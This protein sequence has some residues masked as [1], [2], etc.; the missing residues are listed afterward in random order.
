MSK[1]TK[2][3]PDAVHPDDM[4][5]VLVPMLIDLCRNALPGYHLTTVSTV[6]QITSYMAGTLAKDCED[7]RDMGLR[8]RADVEALDEAFLGALPLSATS[9]RCTLRAWRPV[10]I[11]QSGNAIELAIESP[12][13]DFR[14]NVPGVWGLAMAVE[15]LLLPPHSPGVTKTFQ[16]QGTTSGK[17]LSSGGGGHWTKSG[18]ENDPTIRRIEALNDLTGTGAAHALEHFE[19]YLRLTQAP[20]W[21]DFLG[22]TDALVD[23]L[24]KFVGE[25]DELQARSLVREGVALVFDKP[26]AP[27]VATREWHEAQWREQ[28]AAWF[29]LAVRWNYGVLHGSGEIR[30]LE[31]LRRFGNPDAVAAWL[32]EAFNDLVSERR[33]KV[34][35]ALREIDLVMPG[36]AADVVRELMDGDL[37]RTEQRLRELASDAAKARSA[38]QKQT[39]MDEIFEVQK[40]LDYRS[41]MHAGRLRTFGEKLAE[42]LWVD[43]MERHAVE[44]ARAI[45]QKFGMYFGTSDVLTPEDRYPSALGQIERVRWVLDAFFKGRDFCGVRP[46]QNHNKITFESWRKPLNG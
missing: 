43:E 35:E 41:E 14:L 38:R 5:A 40:S 45:G 6:W 15:R 44:I 25:H 12:D 17:P 39:Y 26:V 20:N 18:Y 8:H 7:E 16:A 1:K 31:S 29:S 27:P 37:G 11:S 32:S 9:G 46:P 23:G 24:A 30:N 21:P 13:A 42:G 2:T 3:N 28:A 34:A 33:L 4:N 22:G 36:V 19:T 10:P